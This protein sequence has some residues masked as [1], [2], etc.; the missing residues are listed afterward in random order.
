M[1]INSVDIASPAQIFRGKRLAPARNG[2][3][4]AA[5]RWLRERLSPS[6]TASESGKSRLAALPPAGVA[7]CQRSPSLAT[8]AQFWETSIL[9]ADYQPSHRSPNAHR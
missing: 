4:G 5:V 6:E 9:S 1:G 8:G 7:L 3:N 2:E